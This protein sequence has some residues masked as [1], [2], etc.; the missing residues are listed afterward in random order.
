MSL[1]LVKVFSV[2]LTWTHACCTMSQGSHRG[3]WYF[4]NGTRL[5]FPA[6]DVNTWKIRGAQRVELRRN[7]GTTTPPVGSMSTGGIYNYNS[8]FQLNSLKVYF[9]RRYFI[10]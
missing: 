1:V 6:T 2:I 8:L 5:P 7:S 9:Y 3:D 10:V 4:P